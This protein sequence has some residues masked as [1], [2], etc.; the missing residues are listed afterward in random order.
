MVWFKAA[1]KA[2]TDTM[3]VSDAQVLVLV[4]YHLQYGKPT[5]LQVNPERNGFTP[6][7]MCM[8]FALELAEIIWC[9][10]RLQSI[11]HKRQQLLI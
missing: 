8:R 10:I 11:P 6:L 9:Q 4:L 3:P 7:M 5:A 2:R 1:E